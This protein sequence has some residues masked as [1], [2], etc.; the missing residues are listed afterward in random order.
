M[1]MSVFFASTPN[2]AVVDLTGT[3]SSDEGGEGSDDNGGAGPW[4]DMNEP[5]PPPHRD[6]PAPMT[7]EQDQ[8]FANAGYTTRDLYN[9]HT[10]LAHSDY[11]STRSGRLLLRFFPTDG[12]RLSRPGTAPALGPQLAFQRLASS[13]L[14]RHPGVGDNP[15]DPTKLL[16]LLQRFAPEELAKAE[17]NRFHPLRHD[18]EEAKRGARL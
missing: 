5:A 4:G 16:S 3:S 1:L 10:Q 17:L 8:T 9:H 18:V 13:Y 6:P 11:Y 14:R 2:N 12:R 15:Q 7:P